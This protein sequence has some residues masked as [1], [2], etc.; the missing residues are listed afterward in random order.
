MK[1]S[2][3]ILLFHILTAHHSSRT[4]FVSG[5]AQHALHF[6][7]SVE[8]STTLLTFAGFEGV[9]EH[10]AMTLFSIIDL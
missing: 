1:V 7:F 9:D 3:Y 5:Q 2:G 4:F 8:A 10:V 6:G